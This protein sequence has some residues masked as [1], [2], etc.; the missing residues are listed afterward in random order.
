MALRVCNPS[1]TQE[2]ETGGLG[3]RAILSQSPGQPGALEPTAT[4][5]T[6]EIKTCRHK[7]DYLI[8]LQC[9]H[10]ECL[11]TLNVHFIEIWGLLKRELLGSA[12]TL[13]F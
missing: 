5:T 9:N 6:N 2:G 1:S 13:E 8:Q 12:F 7:H 10:T 3:I 4:A 11:S